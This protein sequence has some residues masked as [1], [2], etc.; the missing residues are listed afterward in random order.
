MEYLQKAILD[1]YAKHWHTLRDAGFIS[2]LKEA[3]VLELQ[4]VYQQ[5]VDRNFYVNKWCNSCVAEMVRIL[6]VA[7]KYDEIKEEKFTDS[8]VVQEF[9]QAFADDVVINEKASIAD[10]E[11]VEQPKPQPKKR[12]RK[13]KK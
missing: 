7:T 13:K 9:L 6:Y 3:D 2:N 5:L 4:S 11:Q 8:P 12:G 1:K 10:D